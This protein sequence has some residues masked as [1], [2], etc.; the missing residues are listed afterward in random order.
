MIL[1]LVNDPSK[2]EITRLTN[3]LILNRLGAILRSESNA[4]QNLTLNTD[5]IEVE[6]RHF[7]IVDELVALGKI[8]GLQNTLREGRSR[9]VSATIVFQ[10]V[11]GVKQVYGD[12]GLEEFVDLCNS[13]CVLHT[14]GPAAELVAKWFGDEL[15]YENTLSYDPEGYESMHSGFA[16][17]NIIEASLLRNLRHIDTGF[18][19]AVFKYR[20]N[21][22]FL[23]EIPE[24]EFR[25]RIWNDE[26]QANKEH[27]VFEPLKNVS[28][29]AFKLLPFD[30]D[31][32]DRL[33]LPESV[34]KKHNEHRNKKLRARGI[35]LPL[36]QAAAAPQEKTPREIQEHSKSG[37]KGVWD[38]FIERNRKN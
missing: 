11:P 30:E 38:D 34:R 27:D 2:E 35:D 32:Y 9:G 13:W 10:N 37:G 20:G 8:P 31:D 36:P 17:D 22:P 33:R 14:D 19:E 25:A 26:T 12:D 15:V 5:G 28:P 21:K 23:A 24:A 18:T 29:D 16:R 6:P 3:N 7:Y 4:N 1:L